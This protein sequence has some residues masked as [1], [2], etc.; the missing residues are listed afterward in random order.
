MASTVHSQGEYPSST[1]PSIFLD[2][3]RRE[4][5]ISSQGTGAGTP[6]NSWWECASLF[7]KTKVKLSLIRLERNFF[8]NPF[9]IRVFLFLSYSFGMETIDTFIH[10]R[11]SLENHTRFQTKMS[12]VYTR[13]HTKTTQKPYPMGRQIRESIERNVRHT[14]KITRVTEVARQER[15]RLSPLGCAR[16][17]SP[18]FIQ[19]P[20]CCLKKPYKK[21][22]KVQQ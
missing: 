10:S 16:A 11:S 18:P 21:D 19:I 5:S 7:S 22:S 20:A 4:R 3:S 15:D 13:F 17:L 9:R 6:G 2:N 12:K 1:G 14:Q 8:S